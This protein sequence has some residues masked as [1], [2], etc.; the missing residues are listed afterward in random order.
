MI[1]IQLFITTFLATS[2]FIDL[3]AHPLREN[4]PYAEC[5][6][7]SSQNRNWS[8]CIY[9]Y[10]GHSQKVVYYFHG[11]TGNE[12]DWEKY[13]EKDMLQRWTQTHQAPPI[14]VSVSFGKVWFLAEQ[15]SSTSSGLFEVFRDHSWPLLQN[16]LAPLNPHEHILLGYSMGGLNASQLYFKIPHVF[17]RAAIIC[18]AMATVSPHASDE[19]VTEYILRTGAKRM[20]VVAAL[21][22]SKHY[23]P[24]EDDWQKHSPLS[25]AQ[26]SL[27]PESAPI[28]VSNGL[29][30][31][32]GFHEGN[33]VFVDLAVTKNTPIS[34]DF[35]PG[36]GHC[37]VN[38][39]LI[40]DFL[41]L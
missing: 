30:D 29:A 36:G 13:T 37:H 17:S 28:Y 39:S 40:A 25:L 16:K 6:Q 1:F 31:E 35:F 27:R 20:H 7:E 18:G 34:A 8:Y 23:F 5:S 38:Q 11:L 33:K 15:N 24:T 9:K 41:V 10:P 12:R 14:V 21:Q 32:F 4:H 3:P 2:Q 26:A 22:I 19:A